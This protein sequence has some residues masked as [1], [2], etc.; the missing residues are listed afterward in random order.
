[1]KEKNFE[2]FSALSE[3]ELIKHAVKALSVATEQN[4]ELTVRNVDVAVVAQSG[5]KI[6]SDEVLDTYV[7][8]VKADGSGPAPMDTD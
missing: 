8:A 2:S 7:A 1:M 4:T 3:N 6:L 5:V